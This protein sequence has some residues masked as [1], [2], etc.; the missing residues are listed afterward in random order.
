[1]GRDWTA[2]GDAWQERGLGRA[3]FEQ[4][5]AEGESRGVRVF[6][7]FVHW[8][9]R[10]VIR[11]VDRFATVLDRRVEAGIVKVAFMRSRGTVT[12]GANRSA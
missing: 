9:N 1:V 10:R 11:A 7:A 5:I 2:R 4:L 12:R 8:S 6:V 3:L